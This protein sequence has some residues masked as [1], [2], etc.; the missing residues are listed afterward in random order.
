MTTFRGA[1]NDTA[2]PT[3]TPSE[4]ALLKQSVTYNQELAGDQQVPHV[5][6][7]GNTQTTIHAQINIAYNYSSQLCP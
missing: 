1:P 6:D 4:L 5:T 2:T 3:Y 7:G